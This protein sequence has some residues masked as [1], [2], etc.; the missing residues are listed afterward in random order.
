M[1]TY[2]VAYRQFLLF[3]GFTA[4][5]S[6]TPALYE[7]LHIAAK[8]TSLNF[9]TNIFYFYGQRP[10]VIWVDMAHTCIHAYK[11]THTRKNVYIYKYIC[12]LTYAYLFFKHIYTYRLQL[13]VRTVSQA[14]NQKEASFKQRRA[15]MEVIYFSETEPFFRIARR[16]NPEKHN[17]CCILISSFY[18]RVRK[19][20]KLVTIC[21]LHVFLRTC[22]RSSF[23]A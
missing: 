9:L 3:T 2:K 11:H 17:L 20:N 16:Y 21:A 10:L 13:Q 4:M 15:K 6:A 14:R 23:V 1:A 18:D 12:T 5:I 22:L 19:C 8:L 7:H